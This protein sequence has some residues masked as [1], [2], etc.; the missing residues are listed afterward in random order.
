[1]IIPNVIW[2]DRA[3]RKTSHPT[4][5]P[6]TRHW[7]A[8][9]LRLCGVHCSD[10][11]IRIATQVATFTMR[12]AGT[13]GCQMLHLTPLVLGLVVGLLGGAAAIDPPTE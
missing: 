4:P 12:F 5:K 13:A 8:A 1:M 7:C 3:D 10:R 9:L 11:R 6:H 2:S